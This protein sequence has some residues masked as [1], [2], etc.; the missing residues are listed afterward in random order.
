MVCMIDTREHILRT[1]FKLFLKK[2]FKAVTM[3]E[4]EKETGLTKGAFYH[5]FKNKEEI[6]IEVINKY[7]LTNKVPHNE[8]IEKNGTLLEYIH[9]HFSH[10]DMITSKLKEITGVDCPDSSS[11]SLIMEAKEY[12]PGFKEKLKDTNN[13]IYDTWE[14]M[15]TRAKENN[16]IINDIESDILSENFIAIGLSIF[17]YILASRSS[18]YAISMIKLQYNQ[19]YKLIKR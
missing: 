7:Y 15:I 9:L 3:S 8:E 14:K 1:A 10:L 5:Y 19:L 13:E 4:L 18:E 11:V 12:Y 2:S 16:E 6:Y 17:R